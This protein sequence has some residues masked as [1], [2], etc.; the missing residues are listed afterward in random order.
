M[1]PTTEDRKKDK[2]LCPVLFYHMHHNFCHLIGGK[3]KVENTNFVVKKSK[4][5]VWTE[6]VLCNQASSIIGY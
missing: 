1:Y 4:N 2:L 6:I 5:I 3:Q